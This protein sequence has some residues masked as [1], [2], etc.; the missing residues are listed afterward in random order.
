MRDQMLESQR[1]VMS[2]LSQLLTKELRKGRNSMINVGEDNEE[3]LY[4]PGF[5]SINDQ[6]C[7][8][9]VPIAIRSQ[10]HRVGTSAPM[11]YPTGS[12]SNPRNSPTNHEVPD[13]DEMEGIEKAKVELPRHLE[14]RYK[15]LEEKL[16]AME[17]ADYHHGIDAKD[18]SWSLI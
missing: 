9:D 1:N 13:L 18:L 2:Q 15:W 14:D 6:T 3:P 16:R 8:Q 4:P 17:N 10:Q 11:N 12:G 7:P 5:T